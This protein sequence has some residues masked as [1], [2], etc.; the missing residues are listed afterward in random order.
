MAIPLQIAKSEREAYEFL[1]RNLSY[2]GEIDL[3]QPGIDRDGGLEYP[4]PGFG[5]YM[6]FQGTP[7]G[8]QL[9]VFFD[10][11]YTKSILVR[12]GT[13]FK[14][15]P[16]D[17][18][19]RRAHSYFDRLYVQ[20][21]A[22]S[23]AHGTVNLVMLGTP[24]AVYGEEPTAAGG[25]TIVG[26]QATITDEDLIRFGPEPIANLNSARLY[27]Q[28]TG[29]VDD[30]YIVRVQ[31]SPDGLAWEEVSVAQFNDLGP[32]ALRSRALPNNVNYIRVRAQTQE[33]SETTGR[34]WVTG[35]Y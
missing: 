23:A 15:G 9:R 8:A 1:R 18:E 35:R 22:D 11:D 28:N 3:A 26:A 5:F 24:E 6:S 10:R 19:G 33:G 13:Y 2:I 21:T 17:R 29:A 34:F 7:P 25:S 14:P 31:I 4:Y 20:R 16:V 27:I 12:P 32:Q 30:I